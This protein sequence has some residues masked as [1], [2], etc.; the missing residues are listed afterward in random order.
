MNIAYAKRSEDTEQINVILWANRN[1]SHYPELTDLY[2]V[3]N[4]GTRNK[5]EAVKLK[6]MGVKPGVSDLHLPY[7]RGKYNSLYIEMKYGNNTATYEQT[8]FL[9]RMNMAG[10]LAVICYGAYAAIEVLEKYL[11]LE[12]NSGI[13]MSTLVCQVKKKDGILIFKSAP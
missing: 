4:G 1:I 8:K 2:H 10:N 3:P 12:E 7:P 5:A 11:T 6:Q 9:Q 13:D